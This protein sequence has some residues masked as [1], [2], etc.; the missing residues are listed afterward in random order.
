MADI[1]PG[2]QRIVDR[3][4]LTG[5]PTRAA[6]H[7]RLKHEVMHAEHTQLP[8]GIVLIDIDR[9]HEVN[10]DL[11]REAGDR[12]LSECA[13]LWRHAIRRADSLGR[14][15]G[16]DFG[17][18]LPDCDAAGAH[19]VLER[20]R[21]ATPDGLTTS[22]GVA[23]WQPPEPAERLMLRA[24]RALYAAKRQGRDRVASAR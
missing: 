9:F 14:L 6:W 19:E 1:G 3:D 8:L 5:L 16:D 17:L 20:V 22:I 24:D 15:G 13:R 11:G 12:V 23:E 10:E 2:T 18:L 7:L 4:D 21:E